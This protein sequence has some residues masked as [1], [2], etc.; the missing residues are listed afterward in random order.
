MEVRQSL[1][2]VLG[3]DHVHPILRRGDQT[4]EE[5]GGHK[6]PLGDQ[7]RVVVSVENGEDAVGRL[8]LRVLGGVVVVE[9]QPIPVVEAG[10]GHGVDKGR[11][12]EG[13]Q[14]VFIP[15]R[16]QEGLALHDGDGGQA[17]ERGAHGANAPLYGEGVRADVL[18]RA[19]DHVGVVLHGQQRVVEV[20]VVLHQIPV[21]M[22]VGLRRAGHEVTRHDG[23]L[24]A[25]GDEIVLHILVEGAV[26]P[27]AKLHP[28]RVAGRALGGVPVA[29]GL[30][31]RLIE[32]ALDAADSTLSRVFV[33]AQ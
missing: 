25:E 22:A 10:I 20:A 19:V 12:V 7:G 16:E 14:T 31:H 8:V 1:P 5:H 13:V 15:L 17:Q 2:V 29:H 11:G 32:A 28:V 24:H 30:V 18:R 6:A 33:L 23:D 3:V 4:P 27:R 26:H 21:D 9:D